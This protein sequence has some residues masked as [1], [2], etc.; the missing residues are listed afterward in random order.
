MCR[1]CLAV[2]RLVPRIPVWNLHSLYWRWQ[3]LAV[4]TFCLDFRPNSRLVPG[5]GY[6][7]CFSEVLWEPQQRATTSHCRCE[8]V[9][10]GAAKAD[11]YSSKLP[12]EWKLS[13]HLHSSCLIDHKYFCKPGSWCF[14]FENFVSTIVLAI[15]AL[16]ALRTSTCQ[17]GLGL[18]EP[19][20]Y[21][22][23]RGSVLRID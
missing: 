23:S 14:Y 5:L 7:W 22:L 13:W 12:L 19:C 17:F 6:H 21:S 18:G 2:W 1:W 4:I 16:E 20:R 15:A 3:V 10:A 8:A 11:L 9:K